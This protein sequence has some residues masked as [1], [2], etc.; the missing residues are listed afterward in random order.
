MKGA[1][2]HEEAEMRMI[3]SMMAGRTMQQMSEMR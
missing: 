1:R 3:K 2:N